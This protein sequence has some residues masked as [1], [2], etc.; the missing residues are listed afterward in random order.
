MPLEMPRD[1]E[2]VAFAPNTKGRGGKAWARYERYCSANKLCQARSLGATYGDL[3][4][5]FRKGF[6]ASAGGRTLWRLRTLP[7]GVEGW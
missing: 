4:Y 5:D 1:A 3:L 7:D 6:L 2:P